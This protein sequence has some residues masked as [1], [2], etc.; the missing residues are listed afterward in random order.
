VFRSIADLQ[1]AINRYLKEHNDDPKPFVWTKPTDVIPHTV[2]TRLSACR[3]L[4][5]PQA[6]RR[7]SGGDRSGC[8]R[9]AANLECTLAA[10]PAHESTLVFLRGILEEI[11][12]DDD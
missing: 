5:S 2:T 6:R 4:W 11:G 3:P 12:G 1:A 8:R 9:R 10:A 7:Y